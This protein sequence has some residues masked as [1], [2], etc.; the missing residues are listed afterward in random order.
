M[1]LTAA[2]STVVTGVSRR[3]AATFSRIKAMLWGVVEG[4]DSVG[5]FTSFNPMS[6]PQTPEVNRELYDRLKKDL[7]KRGLGYIPVEGLFE[8]NRE[9]SFLV[10]HISREEIV[11]LG[12][13]YQQ[14]SV[15]WGH[16]EGPLLA[17][18]FINTESGV[19]ET[20]DTRYIN[21]TGEII[22]EQEKGEEK[23]SIYKRDPSTRK[24]EREYGPGHTKPVEKKFLIPF[25]EPEYENVR[26]DPERPGRYRRP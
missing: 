6:K 16:R 19:G 17:L 8:G 3:K 12:I 14:S 18:D 13:K 23:Y 25:F 10:P 2:Y 24:K 26:P 5:I 4:M 15:V 7:M 21:Q 22:K 9:K 1:W 20:V 11:E